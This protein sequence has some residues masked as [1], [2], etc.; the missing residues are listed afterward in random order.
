MPHELK[1][2]M[3][4]KQHQENEKGTKWE[5][6]QEI[7]ITE[8]N[9]TEILQLRNITIEKFNRNFQQKTWKDKRKNKQLWKQVIWNNQVWEEKRMR[10]VREYRG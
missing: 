10:K 2:N 5:Y 4:D 3:T 1:Q 7:E 8:K 9:K 6:Q